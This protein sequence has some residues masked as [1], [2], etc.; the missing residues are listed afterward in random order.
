MPIAS[1]H[2][3]LELAACPP[4]V[5]RVHAQVGRFFRIDQGAQHLCAARDVDATENRLRVLR[6]IV[7]TEDH[8]EALRGNR[9]TG[10]DRIGPRRQTFDLARQRGQIDVARA[11]DHQAHRAL[12]PVV[13]QQHDRPGEVRV[14]HL[15]AG[16]E[17]RTRRRGR[18]SGGRSASRG[19]EVSPSDCI[20]RADSAHRQDDGQQK[21]PSG[22]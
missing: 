1:R 7:G 2:L 17:E 9:A 16:D 8:E 3:A 5:A 18:P 6:W 10:V 13:Q 4:G 12:G 21:T 20:R 19:H 14:A 22:N 15:T 11:V